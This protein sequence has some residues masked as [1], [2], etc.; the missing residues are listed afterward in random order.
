MNES[1]EPLSGFMAATKRGMP[2]AL[3]A[4]DDDGNR[5]YALRVDQLTPD[6]DQPRRSFA[7]AGLE[8]LAESLRSTGQVQPIGVGPAGP[9]GKYTIIYGERRWRAMQLADAMQEKDEQEGIALPG[10]RRDFTRIQ[11]IITERPMIERRVVQLVENIHREDLSAIDKAR[12]VDALRDMLAAEARAD[13]ETVNERDLDR[14]MAQRLR[15]QSGRRVRD[16]LLVADLPE[17]L[18]DL[19]QDNGLTIKHALAAATIDDNGEACAF[20]EAVAE[21]GLSGNQA[22]R[23]ARSMRDEGMDMQEAVTAVGK[24]RADAV[25]SPVAK[26]RRKAY[27]T[28]LAATIALSAIDEDEEMDV[29]EQDAW[30]DALGA[31]GDE[32]ARLGRGIGRQRRQAEAAP[33]VADIMSTDDA[34]AP[35]PF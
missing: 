3:A 27:A 33:F 24:S 5:V 8:L 18:Q 9:D 1:N 10:G 28:L 30:E 11:A 4:G 26:S 12:A 34:A 13:G 35:S 23:A 25:L 19:V 31:I 22:G 32:R 21:E 29:A 7:A 15:L 2:D 14:R 20:L 17:N 16:Y 6:G